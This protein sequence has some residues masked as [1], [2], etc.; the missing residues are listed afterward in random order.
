VLE[1]A[2]ERYESGAWLRL[3]D[4]ATFDAHAPAGCLLYVKRGGVAQLRDERDGGAA[5]DR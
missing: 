1:D 2:Q 3:P 4:G 5:A